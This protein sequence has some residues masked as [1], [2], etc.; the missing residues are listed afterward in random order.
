MAIDYEKFVCNQVD[1]MIAQIADKTSE[2]D[3]ARIRDA[4]AFAHD[5]H[6]PQRRRSGEPYI[7][8]PVA[9]AR[10]IAL[11]LQLGPNPIIAGFLHD[12]VEDTPHTIEEIRA[13]FGDDVAFLVDVVT[14][15]KCTDNEDSVQ[16]NNFR[17]LLK[18]LQYDIRAVLIK[19]ADRLHNMRT[20]ASMKPEKQMKIA[21]ETDYF[22]APFANRLGL[23]S[24]RRELENL[25]FKYRCPDRFERL[26]HLLKEDQVRNSDHL[27]DFTDHLVRIF[28]KRGINVRTEVR[29]RQPYSIYQSMRHSGRDFHHV[30]Y[31]Y[32]IRLIYDSN[33]V[34]LPAG[35][36]DEKEKKEKAIS[37]KIYSILTDHFKER[38][39]S[40]IN[41]IDYPKENGYQSLHIQL[42]GDKGIWEEIHISSEHM[43]ERARLGLILDYIEEERRE[44]SDGQHAENMDGNQNRERTYRWIDKFKMMLQDISEK[45]TN[46]LFMDSV[47][48]TLYSEDITV[49]D[50][51]GTP[52]QLPR[53]GTA[54]DYAFEI[55]KGEHAQYARINGRLQSL[56]A[57][58]QHGDCVEIGENPDRQPHGEW[59]AWAKTYK[60]KNFL[61]PLCHPEMAGRY[62]RCEH[63]KPLPGHEVI[64][65]CEDD[66]NVTVHRRDCRHVISQA[67]QQGDRIRNVLFPECE[68]RVYPVTTHLRGIDRDGLLQD[69][70]NCMSDKLH[71]SMSNMN[72][73]TKDEI[74][75]CTISYTVH[76]A[77]ELRA[78]VKL[79]ASIEGV[80]EVSK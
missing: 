75:D 67:A 11:E 25:S 9:V 28:Q 14:K 60:A 29:W 31:R 53:G 55:G 37:L 2:E 23:H 77:E 71:I 19:L 18:S 62:R 16:E 13:R 40:M 69:I 56:K 50:P 17:Q 35:V 36:P 4:F 66:T 63:C 43:V 72:I 58:L 80:D 12:V 7:I 32:I 59:F 30:D 33:E 64:G 68:E 70:V 38:P 52:T 61:K 39:G 15:R 1:D 57:V 20:L 78:A 49:Y 48:S 46:T 54:L 21:G 74:F 45:N 51:T 65:F 5:A 73:E 44:T 22:Y 41:Y 10:I 27:N 47:V 79:L 6:A 26:S 8:H 42:L 76:S 34:E 3:I 24:V